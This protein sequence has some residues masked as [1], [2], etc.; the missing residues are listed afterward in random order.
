MAVSREIMSIMAGIEALAEPRPHAARPL[1]GKS[2]TARLEAMLRTIN[3]TVL[4]RRLVFRCEGAD[5][6]AL[7]ARSGRL[8]SIE[9]G[10]LQ[11]LDEMAAALVGQARLDGVHR[12]E[13]HLAED[14]DAAVGVS[15]ADLRPACL[16]ALRLAESEDSGDFNTRME[17]LALACARMD[18]AGDVDDRRGDGT[19]LPAS[20]DAALISDVAAVRAAMLHLGGEGFLA[21]GAGEGDASRFFLAQEGAEARIGV[22]LPGKLDRLIRAWAETRRS[23][24][25]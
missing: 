16:A 13:V 9:G 4:P 3:G 17:S 18:A 23:D 5:R 20:N 12:F 15:T 14:A 7:L 2:A 19:R 10:A 21:V 11:A 1:P 24:N 8:I 22:T 25:A 6:I